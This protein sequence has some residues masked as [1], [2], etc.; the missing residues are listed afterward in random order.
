[1]SDQD[2]RQAAAQR[3]DEKYYNDSATRLL[4]L[5]LQVHILCSATPVFG[6]PQEQVFA[7]VS[8]A[9]ELMGSLLCSATVGASRP[10]A[11]KRAGGD[12]A[13]LSD[14]RGGPGH[15]PDLSAG[16]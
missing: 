16:G 4:T 7:R 10:R 3:R 8:L 13:I 11:L 9:P 6:N 1:M 12:E 15:A 14:H 2:G 5:R